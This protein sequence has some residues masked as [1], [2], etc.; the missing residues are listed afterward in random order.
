MAIFVSYSSSDGGL[1]ASAVVELL[2][3]QGFDVLWDGDLPDTHPLS[4]PDWMEHAVRDRTVLIIV[5]DDYLRALSSNDFMERLGVRYEAD[6][7]RQKIYDH[8]GASGC[9]VLPIVPPE[10]DMRSLPALL[11]KLVNH[12][13]DPRT[14]R[15]EEELVR[16]VRALEPGNG[17]V[18]MRAEPGVHRTRTMLG[19]LQS[20][21]PS[22]QIAYSLA[23]ELV[24][25]GEELELARAF[26]S[27]VA[28]A[29][30]RG[31]VRL[32]NRLSEMCL[33]TL[34]SKWPFKGDR[35]LK[36][37]IL[38]SG[39]AW[40][41]LREHRFTQAALVAEDGTQ[42]ADKSRDLYLAARGQRAHARVFLHRATE[43]V[44][45]DRHY[46]LGKCEHLL[47]LATNQ[48]RSIRGP[49]SEEVGVCASLHAE[50][51]LLWYEQEHE[52]A[53][54]NEAMARAEIA[55]GLLTPGTEP[56]HWLSVLQARLYLAEGRRAPGRSAARKYHEGRELVTNVVDTADFPEVVARARQ[57][58]ADLL[59]ASRERAEALQ[60]L[61]S[62]EKSFRRIGCDYAAA[63][64]WWSVAEIDSTK[65]VNV[66]L[67][68][69]DVQRLVDLAPD[70]RHRR[71][72]VLEHVQREA[73]RRSRRAPD[74]AGLV[75]H[76]QHD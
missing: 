36:A 17:A 34:E 10:I 22:D 61:L 65:L 42:L 39:Q 37:E 14:G 5:S 43:S 56:Y 75:D 41:L 46:Y 32:V 70:P 38:I 26:T 60:D 76:V 33:R 50:K 18:A 24:E 55:E 9:P 57:V 21:P 2:R 67:S 49:S 23:R 20:R 45:H 68:P 13:F 27:V 54:L 29:K 30:A 44:S 1:T 66:R 48:F 4:I 58:R 40:H 63:T 71:L 28:V 15:G 16:S 52:R 51:W 35:A 31:D 72:A 11:R 53:D 3:A 59:L 7:V 8:S 19:D 69:A 25:H 12:R 6:L 62:A 74:W 64:C 73:K 47:T